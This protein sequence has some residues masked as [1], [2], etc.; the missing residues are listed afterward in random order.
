MLKRLTSVPIA[1]FLLLS[2][3][4]V[5]RSDAQCT[6]ANVNWDNLEYYITNGN[7]NYT[8]YI[9]TP[10]LFASMVQTQRF[11]I[12]TNAVTIA[13]NFPATGILGDNTT[14]TGEAGSF[15]VGADASFT[16]NGTITLTFDTAV[17][18]VQFSI[19][20]LDVTQNVT[21]T[22]FEG[23]T[24]RAVV[25]TKPAGGNVVIAGNVGTGL[26]ANQAN[27]VN[28]ATL[29]IACAGP[30][31]TITLLFAGTAGNF[32]ISD[33]QACVYRNFLNNY[34]AI[35]EPFTGQPAYVLVVHDLNTIYMLDP[36]TGRAVSLF[37]D[38]DP[39][40]REINNVSYDPYKRV[41]YYSVDGLERCTPAGNPDSIRHIK[42]YD[43]NTETISTLISNVNNTP[44]NIPTFNAG[45]ESG[46]CSFYNGSLFMGVEGYKLSGTRNSGRE[47]VIFRIDFASDSTTPTKTCQV[48]GTP[49]DN[50]TNNIHDWADFVMKDGV[51]YEYNSSITSGNGR[52][53]HIN[54]QTNVATT[55]VVP[56]VV[57]NVP[58][59]AAQ[60]WNGTIY[61]VANEIGVYNGTVSNTVT[62]K[63]TI[64]NA[65]RSVTWVGPAGDAGE[66]FKPKADFGDAPASY[67][68]VA[69]SPALN[70]RDTALRI[71][72]TYDWEWSKNTSSDASGDGSDEDGLAYVPIFAKSTNAYVAQVQVW[73][74]T[75]ADATLCAWFDYNANGVFDASE[76]LAPITVGTMASYQ[77]FY[78]S[79]TGIST[80][81]L[82]GSYTYLRIRM[83][84]ATNTLTT[85]KA[86]G[87]FND[88]ETEDYQVF[89]DD[90]PLSVNMLSFTAKGI[91]SNIVR[92]SWTTTSEEDVAGFGIERSADGNNW[93]MIGF[94]NAK[95][96]G[97]SGNTDYTF[98]DLQAMKGKSYYRLKISDINTTFQ[99]SEIRTVNIKD[100]ATEVSITP[101]PAKTN[102]TVYITSDVNTDAVV[103]L[104]DM[105]GRMLRTEKYR[106]FAGGNS[107]A[108]NN[109][110][111]LPNGTYIVRIITGQQI[112]NRKLVIGKSFF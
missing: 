66:A 107:L 23:V 44:F 21:V 60:S 38:P 100:L 5:N 16:G 7:V 1:G 99:Y 17:S 49:V 32:W 80:P 101:N 64:F 111:Q 65:P 63:Q 35:S 10:A 9:N 8:T 98:N 27:N 50:G 74:N 43:T 55:T 70:E 45:L 13:T 3:V 71:G 108:L 103:L 20:D 57:A 88:G 104:H 25:L 110:D 52:Y 39:R 112:I 93:T 2:V 4:S 84:S 106:L 28:V 67:D 42:K 95:S 22:A 6:N 86:T 56:D 24:P 26:A 78:L 18:N 36:A 37:T 59:Q 94:A 83:T 75:G 47:S 91:N 12:G 51:L 61:W 19:Y 85:S 72:N 102:A 31:T 77:S 34:Y 109:L 58:R 40:V 14:H 105:Q 96:N 30:V 79:W 97:R 69:L 73:N 54:M 81:L 62:G 82:N 90:F 76:G 15:G 29:N 41:I 53:S 33:I 92:L 46:G 11:A 48:W 89:V 68:P 87:Y